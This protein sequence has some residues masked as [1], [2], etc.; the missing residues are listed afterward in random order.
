MAT[1]LLSPFIPM[2]FMGEEYGAKHPFLFFTS[3]NEDLA[4]LVR[5]G[6]RAE[7]KH[8][9]AFQ[10][11]KRRAAIPDPNAPGT[12][13]ASI[14]DRADA[15]MAEFMRGLLALRRD[16]IVPVLP[17]CRSMEAQALAPGAVRAVWRMKDGQQLT[18]ALNLGSAAVD[19]NL[20]DGPVLFSYP[21]GTAAT[22]PPGSMAAC[23]TAA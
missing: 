9:A 7:F 21:A 1:M 16:R 8:F 14:P 11:E 12:F 19:A 2:I 15:G 5:E 20:P 18:L 22:L 6:R 23:I 10:D 4:K 13:D 17:G 3:H